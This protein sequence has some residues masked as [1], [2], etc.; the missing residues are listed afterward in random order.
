M[1]ILTPSLPSSA[2]IQN[3]PANAEDL[4]GLIKG[5]KL[6][7]EQAAGLLYVSLDTLHKWLKNRNPC[8]RSAVELLAYKTDQP[9]PA[10]PASGPA[11][12]PKR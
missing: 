12:E 2:V 8:P 6:T 7:R 1:G 9:I 4:K 11:D 10:M 3:H 5:A